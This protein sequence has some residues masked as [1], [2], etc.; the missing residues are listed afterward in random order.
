MP[1]SGSDGGEWLTLIAEFIYSELWYYNWTVR[2]CQLAAPSPLLSHCSFVQ[3]NWNVNVPSAC[4]KY[5]A[6][7]LNTPKDINTKYLLSKRKRIYETE[8]Y[9]SLFWHS[10]ERALFYILIIKANKMHYFSNLFAKV[11]YMLR[12]S[13]LSIIRS[14]STLYT[15]Q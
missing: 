4:A 6:A 1:G 12:T 10:E 5:G 13:P 8:I 7:I 9:E 11:L 15:R 14:N 2:Y 3:T